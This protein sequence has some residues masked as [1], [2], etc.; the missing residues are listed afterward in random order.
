MRLC[1][2]ACAVLV[3]LSLSGGLAMA[4]PGGR[5]VSGSDLPPSLNALERSLKASPTEPAVVAWKNDGQ[6]GEVWTKLW[7]N[8]R[9]KLYTQKQLTKAGLAIGYTGGDYLLVKQHE[10]SIAKRA[11]RA[12]IKA[13]IARVL[14]LLPTFA[15]Y[16]DAQ[17][18]KAR[19]LAPR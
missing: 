4:Q 9:H 16:R 11:Q 15:Q 19:G 3:V 2:N 18:A 17:R 7:Q 13:P 6:G 1:V 12:G 10:G 8:Q 14:D 5:F